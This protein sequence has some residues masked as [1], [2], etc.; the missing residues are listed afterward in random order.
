MPGVPEGI[1]Q[2][3][4]DE[5][6]EVAFARVACELRVKVL[7]WWPLAI[8]TILLRRGLLGTNP[9]SDYAISKLF[10]IVIAYQF[11][12]HPHYSP[13]A[14]WEREAPGSLDTAKNGPFSLTAGKVRSIYVVGIIF[15]CNRRAAAGNPRPMRV[16]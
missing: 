13:Y 10:P 5:R 1:R 2:D 15:F 4:L 14:S 6:V 8:A 9:Y 7:V 3:L 11:Y 12:Q 16:T